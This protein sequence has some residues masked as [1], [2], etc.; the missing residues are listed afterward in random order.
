MFFSN[1]LCVRIFFRSTSL[2]D[3]IHRKILDISLPMLLKLSWFQKYAQTLLSMRI[4]EDLRLH[5][6]CG[7]IFQV[8]GR[9]F[10]TV[11]SLSIWNYSVLLYLAVVGLNEQKLILERHN[12][13]ISKCFASNDV[14]QN[15]RVCSDFSEVSIVF[16]H[17]KS[18]T[19]QSRK[20]LSSNTQSRVSIKISREN[21][22]FH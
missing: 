7:Y 17:S 2:L 21:F 3:W 1:F 4:I 15:R 16:F 12:F 18:S 9:S 19:M 8:I 22:L 20:S 13:W 14:H 6:E 10:K 5:L 11:T